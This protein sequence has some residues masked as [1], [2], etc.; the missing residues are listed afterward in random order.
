MIG[1]AIRKEKRAAASC[2]RP[3]TTPA[4]MVRPERE[5]PGTSAKHCATPI[6]SAPFQLSSSSTPLAS[7]AIR[8]AKIEDEAVD[9]QHEG[10][11]RRRAEGVAEKLSETIT[12]N[13]RRN[14]R[15]HDEGEDPPVGLDAR[16]RARDQRAKE[17]QTSRARNRETAPSRCRGASRPDRA[18][19]RRARSSIGQPSS[20]G[21]ITAWPRLLIG[22]SSVT[23]C[24]TAMTMAWKSVTL[25][26]LADGEKIADA[27][28]SSIGDSSLGAV[29]GRGPQVH[30]RRNEKR[31]RGGPRR[32]LKRSR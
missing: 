25:R 18:G 19:S 11:E 23:P 4:A 21:R 12:D 15:Q 32:R 24:S 30:S 7:P 6:A 29:R 31:R 5:K 20:R 14:G 26:R 2:L 17:R 16:A 3:A 13:H 22:N 9:D 1:V 27:L 28:H 8:S 10:G